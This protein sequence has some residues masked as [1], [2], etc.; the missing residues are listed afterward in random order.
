[1]R[2]RLYY[3]ALLAI[4]AAGGCAVFNPPSPANPAEPVFA[5]TTDGWVIALYRYEPRSISA[6]RDPVV[7]CHG[8]A[9]NNYF[10]HLDR[11]INFARYLQQRGFDVWLVDLR[12]HGQS[13]LANPFA[14]SFVGENVKQADPYGWTL[15]DHAL[16][17]I[18]AIITEVLKQTGRKKLTW[19]GHSMGGMIMFLRLGV[20]GDDRVA[21]FGAV[22]SPLISPKPPSEMIYEQTYNPDAGIER[23]IEARMMAGI[24]HNIAIVKPVL[25][26]PLDVLYYNR[27]NITNRVMVR[28][29]ANAIENITPK[30]NEQLRRMSKTGE[31]MSADGKTS[32]AKLASKIDLPILL[33][34]GKC[35]ELAPPAALRFAYNTVASSD[36][37][38]RI[39]SRA[40]HSAR[41]YGHC[42]IINGLDAEKDVFPF[43]HEWLVQHSKKAAK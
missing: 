22:S 13:R 1:V 35:D 4:L 21:R 17:D 15:E 36:K 7:L 31:F 29:Y 5:K 41:D 26:T 30:V 12:G 18:D 19:I 39:F 9:L 24:L 27:D 3:M 2:V 25:D 14:G 42:D 34:T 16:K 23:I 33:V 38:F 32:Y 10:W 6:A 43:I 28:F 37:T 20:M 40:S 11:R 8:N